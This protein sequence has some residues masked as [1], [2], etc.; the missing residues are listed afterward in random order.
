MYK[1]SLVNVKISIYKAVL[2]YNRIVINYVLEKS[3]TYFFSK[4]STIFCIFKGIYLSLSFSIYIIGI[5]FIA[6]YIHSTEVLK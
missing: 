1:D 4:Y 5:L 2:H 6:H 3:L